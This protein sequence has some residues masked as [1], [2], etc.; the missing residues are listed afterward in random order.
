[1]NRDLQYLNKSINTILISTNLITYVYHR[2]HRDGYSC[3]SAG[4]Y[5]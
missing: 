3:S 1:M 5:K 4:E 2:T